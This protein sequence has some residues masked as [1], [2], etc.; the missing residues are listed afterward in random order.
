MATTRSGRQVK[1]VVPFDPQADT[2]GPDI[3]MDQP[4][5][6]NTPANQQTQR[7]RGRGRGASRGAG[8]GHQNETAATHDIGILAQV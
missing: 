7:G 1:P 4:L 8:R 6:N 3:S 2:L 5:P